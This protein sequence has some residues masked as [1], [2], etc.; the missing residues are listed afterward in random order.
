MIERKILKTWQT[1]TFGEIAEHISVRIDPIIGDEKTYIGLEHLDNDSLQVKRWGS[2]VV[3]KGQKLQIKKGDILFAK[4]NAYLK[5]V[6]LAPFDGIF[7]AHGM[8]L[9]PRGSSILPD[10][11]PFFMQSDVFMERAIS[12]SEGSLSPTIKWS[13]LSRQEFH[14]PNLEVQCSLI[15][16]LKKLDEVL[17]LKKSIKDSILTL[18]RVLISRLFSK[19]KLLGLNAK[20]MSFFNTLDIV[21]G[22][23]DPTSDDFKSYPHIA[24]DNMEKNLATLLP[25]RT[26]EE[27]KVKSG[28]YLFDEGHVLYSKIRP[29]LRKVVFPRI[30]GVCS[31]D[32]YPLK[33][34]NGLI[35]DYLFYLLQSE[36]FNSFAISTSMRTGMPKINR[37]DLCAYTYYLPPI[38][39][40]LSIVEKIKM[41]DELYIE[42]TSAI[43]DVMKLKKSYLNTTR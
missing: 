37:E 21:S 43:N 26:A 11:L 22:Q 41:L 28:K 16:T 5:R 40:Q 12:I 23:V 39:A 38:E 13:T 32:V 15:V 1:V 4:R 35:T 20:K 3:L 19:K 27:D 14:L 17:E 10:F 6:A 33:G 18:K 24:P 29:N 7:S 31:A 9:R 8:V 42:T 25:Y 2:D 34:K 36:H 30:K